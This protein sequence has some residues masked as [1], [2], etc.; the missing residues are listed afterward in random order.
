MITIAAKEG[1]TVAME[2]NLFIIIDTTL[3]KELI[4][5]GYAREFIS[6]VQQM[7]KTANFEMMDKISISFN[8]DD[9]IANAVEMHKEYIMQETLAE[10]V[11][12]VADTGLETQDLNG[13]ETGMKVEKI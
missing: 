4:D 9:E 2:N 5:E 7:R 11:E 10:N 13:H 6:K 8:G 12:R 3:T 1:F